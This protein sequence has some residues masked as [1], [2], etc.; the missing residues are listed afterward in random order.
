MTKCWATLCSTAK[1]LPGRRYSKLTLFEHGRGGPLPGAA[2]ECAT[3]L[4]TNMRGSGC[5]LY[6]GEFRVVSWRAFLRCPYTQKLEATFA[7]CLVNL[8]IGSTDKVHVSTHLAD[9]L[10]GPQRTGS[11][12]I[13]ADPAIP[14]QVNLTFG[15]G[16]FSGQSRAA[17]EYVDQVGQRLREAKH[18]IGQAAESLYQLD[19]LA[20]W[21]GKY[22]RSWEAIRALSGRASALLKCN[23]TITEAQQ[24]LHSVP[25]GDVPITIILEGSR[26]EPLA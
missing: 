2:T 20:R 22:A 15:P 25:S 9:L 24:L 10:R 19:Q 4:D 17:P 11:A 6:G 13:T 5:R 7:D 18:A 16:S 12:L 3:E 26:S 14:F 8:V 1:L 23:N 21:G